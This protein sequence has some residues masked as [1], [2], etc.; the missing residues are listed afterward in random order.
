MPDGARRLLLHRVAALGLVVG[1]VPFFLAVLQA[2]EDPE[3]NAGEP[4]PRT[5]LA[6]SPVRIVDVE[7]TETARRVAS[8]S[9]QPVEVFDAEAPAATISAVR[10]IFTAV[11][12]VRRPSAADPG[13]PTATAEPGGQVTPVPPTGEEQEA[14]LAARG[15]GL[16]SE[17]I[18]ALVAIDTTELAVVEEETVAVARQLARLRISEEE[19]GAVLDEQLRV[20]LALRSFPDDLADVVADPII[21]AT[22]RPTVTVD[23]DAT[24][25]A[26]ERAATEVAEVAM[27][28]TA[29]QPIVRRGQV[30]AQ[31][32]LAALEQQG[33]TGVSPVTQFLKAV[34][35]L[36]LTVLVLL[37]YLV[38]MRPKVWASGRRLVLLA[39]LI[40]AY[41]LLVAVT[42]LLAEA[43]G[44][45]WWYAV[46]VGV[47]AILT[48]LLVHPM[49]GIA[50][51][52][53]GAVLVMLVAPQTAGPVEVFAATTALVS[54]PLFQRTASRSDLRRSILELFVVY[55]AIAAALVAVFGPEGQLGNA[56]LA[57]LANAVVTGVIVQGALPF[58]ETIFR[59]PSVTA[60]LDLADRNHPLLRD[61]ERVAP[62]T[63]QHSVSVASLCER[64]CREVG[65][66]ALLAS[67]AA[68]Y[69]DIGKVHR[70]HFFI[71]NQV[72]IDNPHDELEPRMSALII[73]R[74]VEDG[75]EMATQ[76]RLPPEV[77]E[78]IGSHHGTMVVTFFYRRA[79]ELAGGDASSVDEDEFRY[80]GHKPGSREAAILL[81]A[82]CSEAATR[83]AAQAQGHLDR[84]TIQAMVDGL[85]QERLDDGQFDET[86]LSLSELRRVQASV[87]ESLVGIYHPRIAYPAARAEEERKV[88]ARAR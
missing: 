40:S 72:G 53:P 77:V 5:I 46:P 52:V 31:L 13:Q 6:Q 38:R 78:C 21:R 15:L 25:A 57:G 14:A 35:A 23:P 27:T 61:L 16:T 75:V 1:L 17:T 24:A 42:G 69:H 41:A 19:L 64:A 33:E 50:T 84:E 73:R 44:A 4:A 76:H 74:H 80:H 20:E 85:I 11:R 49:V 39:T 36:G 10:A 79:I 70:P 59:V 62:G 51:M 65:A 87:V 30:V 34:A 45:G 56:A 81:M 68:L 55:P 63:Y 88:T 43:A 58:L 7:A 2:A 86:E 67:V 47:L 37:I 48:A 28:W 12:E 18:A 29:G 54:V 82:D 83:S 3:I 22:L 71:E 8:E 26:R 66:D 60:L 9:V 32:E